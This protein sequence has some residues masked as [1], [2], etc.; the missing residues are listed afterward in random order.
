MTVIITNI[1]ALVA[2][3]QLRLNS[4]EMSQAM[5]RLSTG[6]RINSGADDPAGIAVAA[7]LEA[8]SRADRVG[9]RNA[10]DAVSLTHCALKTGSF[11]ITNTES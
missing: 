10:N 1:P 3:N 5:E 8:A 2:N 7:R 11:L 9:I 4:R 6:K